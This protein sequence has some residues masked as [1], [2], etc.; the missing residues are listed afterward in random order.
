M[1]I[2]V[3]K[4]QNIITEEQKKAIDN[5]GSQ[6]KTMEDFVSAVKLRPGQFV[7]E[8]HSKGFLN[9]IR[10]IFQNAVDQLMKGKYT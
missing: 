9:M 1:N 4:E 6:I 7:G 8:T 5:Y 10:E 2:I 3:A